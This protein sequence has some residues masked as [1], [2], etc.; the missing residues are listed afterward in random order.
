[1]EGLRAIYAERSD[2]GRGFGI[3]GR[4]RTILRSPKIIDLIFRHANGRADR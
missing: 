4:L 1:M 2:F 3:L